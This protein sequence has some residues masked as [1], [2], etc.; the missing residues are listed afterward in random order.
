MVGNIFWELRNPIPTKNLELKYQLFYYLTDLILYSKIFFNFISSWKKNYISQLFPNQCWGS[1]IFYY[2]TLLL[3]YFLGGFIRGLIPPCMESKPI[4]YGNSTY[5][6]LPNTVV[7]I[8][9]SHQL[10]SFNWLSSIFLQSHAFMYLLLSCNVI[11]MTTDLLNLLIA[12]HCLSSAVV[13][14]KI[15]YVFITLFCLSY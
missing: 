2:I 10:V 15:F 1:S 5:T 3:I 9:P 4:K 14:R 12:F 11:F 8:C 6:T 7:I 13:L